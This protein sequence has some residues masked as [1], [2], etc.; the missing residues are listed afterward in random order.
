MSFLVSHTHGLFSSVNP[1]LP[2]APPLRKPSSEGRVVVESS[3]ANPAKGDDEVEEKEELG[4]DEDDNITAKEVPPDEQRGSF[5]RP[6]F[7]DC[8]G[9]RVGAVAA[10]A[11]DAGGRE[12][13]VSRREIGGTKGV[14]LP[15]AVGNS[16]HGT[17]SNDDLSSIDSSLSG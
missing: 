9:A 5:L 2:P 3:K 15:P 10:G 4:G 1:R 13:R 8:G 11:V 14:P 7:V 17:K 16:L 6:A 12:E